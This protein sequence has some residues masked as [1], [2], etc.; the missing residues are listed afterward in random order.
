MNVF[1]KQ[2]LD[3]VRIARHMLVEERHRLVLLAQNESTDYDT[4]RARMLASA[5]LKFLETL[6]D[7]EQLLPEIYGLQP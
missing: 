5:A 3:A 4:V 2:A 7:T 6:E 1:A